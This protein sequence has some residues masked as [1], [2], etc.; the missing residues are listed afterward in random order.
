MTSDID[1]GPPEGNQQHSIHGP[2]CPHRTVVRTP[3]YIC[4]VFGPYSHVLRTPGAVA[5]SSAGFIGRLP[6]SMISLGVV[7]LGRRRASRTRW[8][9]PSRRVLRSQRPSG[10]HRQRLRGPSWPAP[11]LP[12]AV[13]FTRSAWSRC[14]SDSTPDPLT[15]VIPLAAGAWDDHAQHGFTDSGSVGHVPA[16]PG[17][18]AYAWEASSTV[19]SS[20][21]RHWPRSWRCR[22]IRLLPS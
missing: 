11:I 5:F 12:W 18:M 20:S 17:Y 19:V 6:I 22:S 3:G 16:H 14:S 21:D 1:S 13:G 8:P 15:A 4:V 2:S 7:L 9:G 10:P